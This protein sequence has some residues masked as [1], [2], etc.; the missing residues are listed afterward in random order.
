MKVRGLSFRWVRSTLAE[1]RGEAFGSGMLQRAKAL[2]ERFVPTISQRCKCPELRS[3]PQ[4][5]L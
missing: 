2:L 3:L 1:S 5:Y 4:K